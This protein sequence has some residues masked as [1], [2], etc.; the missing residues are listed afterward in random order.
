[1][2]PHVTVAILFDWSDILSNVQARISDWNVNAPQTLNDGGMV[3]KRGTTQQ[4]AIEMISCLFSD[5][6]L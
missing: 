1:M 5:I 4:H 2:N 6:N 3:K